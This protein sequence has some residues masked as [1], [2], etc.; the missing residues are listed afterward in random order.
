VKERAIFLI[1]IF[2]FL[3]AIFVIRSISSEKEVFLN[4]SLKEIPLSFSGWQGRE[5]KIREKIINVLGVTDYIYRVY[6]K[7]KT[8]IQVYVGYYASQKEGALIH[9]PRH[10]LPAAGWDILNMK[11][12]RISISEKKEITVNELLMAKGLEKELV[13]YWF[14]E[15]ERIITNEYVVKF[16]LIFDRIFKRKSYG[17]LI[18]IS[19]AIDKSLKETEEK[20][21]QFIKDFY[22]I[23]EEFFPKT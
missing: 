13:F 17:A 3:I 18:Q 6:V 5:E 4:K 2:L 16:Y 8:A 23:L 12:E 22:P 1:N 7:D 19:S 9:S 15:R 21:K 10:C 20:T 14:R 11:K